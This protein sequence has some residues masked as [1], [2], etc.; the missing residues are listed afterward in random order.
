METV[1]A[2]LALHTPTHAM[3]THSLPR[4]GLRSTMATVI[5]HLA[6]TSPGA[7]SSPLPLRVPLFFFRVCLKRALAAV[8]CR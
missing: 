5:F 3:S 8:T 7:H 4:T 6:I 1:R 2:G